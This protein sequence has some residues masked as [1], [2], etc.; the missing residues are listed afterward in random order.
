MQGGV[1]PVVSGI[2]ICALAQEQA[3][4]FSMTERAGIV[5]RD[6]TTIV[7]G[8]NVGTSLQ[9]VFYH[10]LSA[11][12]WLVGGRTEKKSRALE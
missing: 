3:D 11:K 7:T 6:Q 1:V 12:A 9:E 8:M 5:K 4:D 10:V 2:W